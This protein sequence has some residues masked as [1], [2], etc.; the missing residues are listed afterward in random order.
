MN[1]LRWRLAHRGPAALQERPAGPEHDGARQRAPPASASTHRPWR[2]PTRVAA[3]VDRHQRRGERQADPEAAT[4]VGQFGIGRIVQRDRGRLQRHAADRAGAR[5]DLAH[6][7][8]HRAGVDRR[9][10]SLG[11]SGAARGVRDSARGRPRTSCGSRRSRSGRPAR[12]ASRV[13]GVFAGST[14]MPQT[15]S[16]HRRRLGLGHATRLHTPVGYAHIPCHGISKRRREDRPMDRHDKPK[17]LNRLKRIEGQVRGV[18]RMVEDDR[19]CID[20]MTQLRG[21]ARGAE[22]RRERAAER[23]PRP[24]HRERHRQ[25]RRRRAAPQGRRADRAAGAL[26]QIAATPPVRPRV[27][28]R[29]SQACYTSRLERTFAGA[30]GAPPST[31]SFKSRERTR[32][33][34]SAAPRAP[35]AA[36]ALQRLGPGRRWR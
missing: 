28:R 20:V 33:R 10:P 5:P 8:M 22:P 32:V 34:A 2:G 12:R 6:L 21:G 14:V 35:C 25:R 3:H 27:R 15:G 29:L 1:M 26:R 24:L 36:R 31:Y 17:L 23:P 30:Y 13:C 19:Y 4:H 9:R 7:G 16:L 18:A 11:G